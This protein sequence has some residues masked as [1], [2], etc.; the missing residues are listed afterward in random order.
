ML[1]RQSL[2]LEAMVRLEVMLR[3]EAM[4]MAEE[5]MGMVTRF[6]MRTLL[7]FRCLSSSE[8]GLWSPPWPRSVSITQYK[9][10]YVSYLRMEKWKSKR[11]FMQS[12]EAKK[13]YFFMLRKETK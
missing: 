6:S 5:V 4:V 12:K 10:L 11:F 9:Y 13:P 1:I 2:R 3:L 7:A 8:S